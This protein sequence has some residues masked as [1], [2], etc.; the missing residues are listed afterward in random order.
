MHNGCQRWISES[1]T[2][3]KHSKVLPKLYNDSSTEVPNGVSVKSYAVI[4]FL[5]SMGISILGPSL[6][7]PWSLIICHRKT[8]NWVTL[9]RWLCPHVFRCW[10]LAWRNWWIWT[11]Y[12]LS[13]R[14][15]GE[16]TCKISDSSHA[17]SPKSRPQPTKER[18]SNR[19]PVLGATCKMHKS[20]CTAAR[21]RSTYTGSTS[22]GAASKVSGVL[23]GE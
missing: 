2:I 17:N 10:E 21:K 15:L 9:W 11:S 13:R 22:R 8:T 23:M 3:A 5:R 18:S 14:S 6:V 4:S 19:R 12:G 7:H 20:L 16:M 1:W